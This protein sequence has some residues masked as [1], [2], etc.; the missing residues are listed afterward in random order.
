MLQLE[1]LQ[2]KVNKE[3]NLGEIGQPLGM[4]VFNMIVDDI[5]EPILTIWGLSSKQFKIQLQ[6]DNGKFNLVNNLS[7]SLQGMMVDGVESGRV[8]YEKYT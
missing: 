1:A 5:L 2:S 3:Y 6:I 8:V 4:P 7:K